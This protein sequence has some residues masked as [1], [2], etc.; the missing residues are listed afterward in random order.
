[1]LPG[2]AGNEYT[3][4]PALVYQLYIK[5]TFQIKLDILPS[6]LDA[7]EIKTNISFQTRTGV[8]RTKLY[9]L[10]KGHNKFL[11]KGHLAQVSLEFFI[12]ACK[13]YEL[14][15]LWNT[16]CTLRHLHAERFNSFQLY[17][18]SSIKPLYKFSIFP[19]NCFLPMR[20]SFLQASAEELA[21][22][23]F[24]VLLAI[25]IFA[26]LVYYAERS[27][28]NPEN[29]FT[30]IPAG[31]WWYVIST[32]RPVSIWLPSN[33]AFSGVSSRFLQLDLAIW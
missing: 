28:P 11:F 18:T 13:V 12:S 16:W 7:F 6:K 21:L 32:Q 3:Y 17:F 14:C 26:A 19:F 31:L 33:D 20:F 27:Q 5:N 25:V 15:A 4:R 8:F 23:V 22:L 29:Q 1:M 10:R 24:F 30:S 9:S 2:G